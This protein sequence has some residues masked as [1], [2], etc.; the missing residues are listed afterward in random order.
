MSENYRGHSILVT[1]KRTW[2][3]VII[4]VET[5]MVLPTKATA[6]LHE[7]RSVAVARAHEL[8][9]LY[10]DAAPFERLEAAL[11]DRIDV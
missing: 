7:G 6:Q 5:G 8:I 11:G 9:D 2:D 10:I 3:A 4:E 1:L